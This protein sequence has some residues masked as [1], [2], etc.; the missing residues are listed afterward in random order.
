MN[1]S[2]LLATVQGVGYKE[3]ME[4]GRLGSKQSEDGCEDAWGAGTH[5]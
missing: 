5:K 3:I 2:H 4:M 1:L